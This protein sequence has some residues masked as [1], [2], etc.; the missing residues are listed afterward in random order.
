MSARVLFC[1]AS[2]LV[3]LVVVAAVGCKEA[4]LPGSEPE[5]MERLAAAFAR[6]SIEC[7]PRGAFES[8]VEPED[9]RD[10]QRI[11][12]GYRAFFLLLLSAES[13]RVDS[14]AFTRCL[15]FLESDGRCDGFA[16]AG[17]GDCDRI[18][19]GTLEGG[20]RCALREEC[21]SGVC[22]SGGSAACGT[23]AA[24]STGALGD[25]CG[26]RP[27]EQGLFC[28]YD[29]PDGAVCVT[30][31][32]DGEACFE[33]IGGARVFFRCQDGLACADDDVCHPEAGAQEACGLD[34][35]CRLDLAC[36]DGV[37][38][39]PLR[40][41]AVGD[42]CDPQG[43]GCGPTLASGLAC[44]GPPGEATCVQA[45]VHAEGER[46]DGGNDEDEVDSSRWCLHA[47]STHRCRIFQGEAEG[48]CVRRPDL[49]DDCRLQQ[50]NVESG[51]CV[52]SDGGNNAVCRAWPEVGERCLVTD[53]RPT[54]GPALSCQ[55][56]RSGSLCAP[57]PFPTTLPAC[58]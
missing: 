13:V 5:D 31:R 4:P 44:E 3:A 37:C 48:T 46:C 39:R 7:S 51:G 45:T 16:G 19:V 8:L 15:A 20:Q 57:Y 22:L 56:D 36:D 52:V 30:L 29:H 49:G 6:A 26:A 34:R 14:I 42:A 28:Q 47:R 25:F 1:P 38:V 12:E 17:E 24:D 41:F 58:G 18:F 35:R 21:A 55:S 43:P 11:E 53:G 10:A 32:E 50:C 23:C 27:C 9:P 40:G 33:D 54:C 2:L